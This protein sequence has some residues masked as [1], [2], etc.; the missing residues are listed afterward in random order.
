M[1]AQR[2]RSTKDRRVRLTRDDWLAT[3]RTSLIE[4]GIAALKIERLA[5]AM[6]VTIGSFYWHFTK[7][8]D[9]LAAL[10][11]DWRTTNSASMIQAATRDDRSPSDRFD[12]FIRI[13][14]E[15]TGYSSAY[16]SAVR[17]WGRSSETVRAAVRE[18]D[19]TRIRLLRTIYSDLGYDDDRAE[20]RARIAYFH[21]VG[22]YAL[23][24]RDDE[25]VR[26]K[27]RPL[28]IEALRDGPGRRG[29]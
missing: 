16:D 20:V 5:A 13:W 11:D 24:L 21:Q 4:G 2:K 25:A 8:D 14:I 18:V 17:E 29:R 6:G 1:A 7:R 15:E 28:Y 26:L 19:L 22:F 10:L 27:L 23:G 9:L 3:A 12:A